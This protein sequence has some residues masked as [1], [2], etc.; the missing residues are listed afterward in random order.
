MDPAT[1]QK[2]LQHSS[3]IL[4][5]IGDLTTM[6]ISMLPGS[7]P[8]ILQLSGQVQHTL[9]SMCISGLLEGEAA[10]MMESV[11]RF[12]DATEDLVCPVKSGLGVPVT[13]KGNDIP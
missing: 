3:L 13:K 4:K 6:K 1:N 5:K 9:N 10:C 2:S 8:D 7:K 12:I 11:T